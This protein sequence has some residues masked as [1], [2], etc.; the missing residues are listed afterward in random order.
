[1]AFKWKGGDN[2]GCIVCARHVDPEFSKS[3]AF[4]R[5]RIGIR[6]VASLRGAAKG[7]TGSARGA[8]WTSSRTIKFLRIY[9]CP[10]GSWL[11]T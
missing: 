7:T 11:S 8:P 9:L 6:D 10:P 3:T 1:M 5:G 2:C 4:G